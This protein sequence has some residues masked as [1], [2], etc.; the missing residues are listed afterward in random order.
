MQLNT[1]RILALITQNINF[2]YSNL[3][4]PVTLPSNNRN[5]LYSY[6]N[7]TSWNILLIK[8]QPTTSKYQGNDL[9]PVTDQALF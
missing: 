1:E 2:R 9:K 5:K 8:A 7:K 6:F 4:A 3:F